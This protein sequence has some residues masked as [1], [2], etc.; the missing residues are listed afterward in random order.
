MGRTGHGCYPV[1]FSLSPFH[2]IFRM[3]DVNS[4]PPLGMAPIL[5][6]Q[7]EEAEPSS[8]TGDAP[9]SEETVQ[10]EGAEPEGDQPA[11]AAEEIFHEEGGN[12]FKTKDD[13]IRYVN[14][15]KGAAARLAH[16]KT[17]AD[18][19]AAHFE[20]LY[21][22]AISAVGKPPAPE[23]PQMSDETREAIETLKKNGLVTAD[24]V[25][26]LVEQAVAP[27][28]RDSEQRRMEQ[29]NEARETVDEFIGLNPDAA[30]NAPALEET[31]MRMER[32]G[33]TG[34]LEQAYFLVTGKV[35]KTKDLSA[36]EERREVKKLAASMA[37]GS[38]AN[39]ATGGT[40]T[41]DVFDGMLSSSIGNSIF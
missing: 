22:S 13:Y 9:A 17:L 35:A 2:F 41:Q 5:D 4:Q 15:S 30:D 7:S 33:I 36:V 11:E 32:A 39:K 38:N 27:F 19:R 37:G 1:S 24:Q 34:G 20:K 3:E 23:A 8:E 6:N 21:T 16:E 40:K 25:K 18:E 29:I 14:K 10:P 26:E 28:K 12:T 31:L